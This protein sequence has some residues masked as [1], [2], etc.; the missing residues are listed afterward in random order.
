[1]TLPVFRKAVFAAFGPKMENATPANVR[2]FLDEMQERMHA[3]ARERE[4]SGGP[5]TLNEHATSYEQIIQ[6]FFSQALRL[7]SDEAIITL[8][9]MAVEMS[10]SS[11]ESQYA[12]MFR[13]LFP[14]IEPGQG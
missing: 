11:L 12:E 13:P 4:T 7:P 9:T 2:D 10:F 6:E 1:M 8:W 14:D 5:M 3:E